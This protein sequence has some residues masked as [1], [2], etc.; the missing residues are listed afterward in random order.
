MRVD[1][2][3][4]RRAVGEFVRGVTLISSRYE[5]AEHAATVGTF[6]VVSY[7]LRRVA[8]TVHRASRLT[9]IMQRSR[10]WGVSLLGVGDAA[11]AAHFAQAGRPLGELP[12]RAACRRGPVTGVALLADALAVLE[13]RTVAE[14]DADDHLIVVGEPVWLAERAGGV[15][16]CDF[17]GV[18]CEPSDVDNPVRRV[19]PWL[20]RSSTTSRPAVT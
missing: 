3:A 8:V 9:A 15:P 19:D 13:C 5:D 6:T 16:L 20:P 2:G 10:A 7:P 17:R 1:A 18:L 14:L 11:L 12:A 4:F